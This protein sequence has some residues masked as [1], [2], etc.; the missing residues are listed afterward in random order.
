[1]EKGEWFWDHNSIHKRAKRS[2]ALLVF[3]NIH[4]LVAV[5]AHP[6]RKEVQ[7]DVFLHLLQFG[8]PMTEYPPIKELLQFVGVPKVGIFHFFSF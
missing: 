8:K 1:M 5:G 4:T 7:I 2:F 3:N 6:N